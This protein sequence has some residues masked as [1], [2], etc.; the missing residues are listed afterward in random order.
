MAASRYNIFINSEN[1]GS[2][3]RL[4]VL[5]EEIQLDYGKYTQ[6]IN[7]DSI[8]EVLQKTSGEALR[9]S[10]SSVFPAEKTSDYKGVFTRPTDFKEFFRA[11]LYR[12]N[13]IELIIDGMDERL[14]CTVESFKV[15]EKGGDVGTVYYDIVFVKYTEMSLQKVTL[16]ADGTVIYSDNTLRPNTLSV[17]VTY[18]VLEGD[19]IQKIAMKCFSDS[20]RWTDIYENNTESIS[21]PSVLSVGQVLKLS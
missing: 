6:S 12:Q 7:I 14:Y 8:G 5:P 3:L 20:S 21:N 17:Q 16:N 11:C 1:F 19:F 10:F 13:V 2:V 9:I 4:P 18:T 15:K